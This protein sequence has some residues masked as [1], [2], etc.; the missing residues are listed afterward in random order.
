M[1]LSTDGFSA[2]S[3]SKSTGVFR[4]EGEFCAGVEGREMF[5]GGRI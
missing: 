4:L 3:A 2:L 1:M 5:V